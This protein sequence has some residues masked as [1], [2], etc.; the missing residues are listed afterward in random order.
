MGKETLLS[1]WQGQVNVYAA[2]QLTYPG[3]KFPAISGLAKP[4]ADLINDT[5]VAG[6]WKGDLLRGLLWN[7]H[8]PLAS[9]SEY[10]DGLVASR[11]SNFI[12]PSW[13][14]A[15]HTI[16]DQNYF[17]TNTKPSF[18]NEYSFRTECKEIYALSTTEEENLNPFGGIKDASL[19]VIGRLARVTSLITRVGRFQWAVEFDSLSV[20]GVSLDW[21]MKEGEKSLPGDIV[22]FLLASSLSN[23]WPSMSYGNLSQIE[24]RQHVNR[25]RGEPCEDEAATLAPNHEE[26][27]DS[28]DEEFSSS[29][30]GNLSDLSSGV[31]INP[32]VDDSAFDVHMS[33]GKEQEA[34]FNQDK[35]ARASIKNRT[36]WGLLLWNPN[37]EDGRYYRIGCFRVDH[38]DRGLWAFRDCAFEEVEVI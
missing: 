33:Y 38:S 20:A 12:S 34:F 29:E 13:S 6:L 19:Y 26:E 27:F 11:S 36:A 10:L 15:A 25:E 18:F 2:R 37:N 9:C 21:E 1:H 5:Y 28:A 31:S 16:V 3:D 7:A 8:G 14:W 24:W 22:M 32:D 4:I 35:E 23:I 30:E 17:T